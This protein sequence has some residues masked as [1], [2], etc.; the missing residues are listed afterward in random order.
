MMEKKEK[1]E[2]MYEMLV[3]YERKIHEKNQKRIR[4]GLK[5]ILI[6]PLIFLIL[7]FWTESNKVIFLILWIVSLF[8]IAAYLILV[9][10]MDYNLQEKLHE[11][12]DGEGESEVKNLIGQELEEAE[13]NFKNA[14]K[15]LDENTGMEAEIKEG[16]KEQAEVTEHA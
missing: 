1:Y 11:I 8:A 3:D 7:L 16:E 13:E 10:Y 2:Q 5:C 15:K 12:S 14:M 6:I 4:I 9:E